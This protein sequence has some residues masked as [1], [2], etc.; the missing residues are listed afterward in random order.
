MSD[1][2]NWEEG[3]EPTRESRRTARAI[4]RSQSIKQV[5]QARVAD[6]A[7]VA[8]EK[9]EQVS[10]TTVTAMFAVARV[11][12]VLKQLEEQSPELSGR[13]TRLADYQEL[14]VAQTI[15]DLRLDLRRR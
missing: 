3:G 8:M 10:V 5:R 15:E 12:G 14:A 13:L 2:V 7:D 4:T 6:E 9:V 1:I 11:N